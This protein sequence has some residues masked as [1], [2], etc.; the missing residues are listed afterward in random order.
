[1]TSEITAEVDISNTETGAFQLSVDLYGK[2]EGTYEET[3]LQ[4]LNKAHEVCPYSNATRGN[5]LVK[6]HLED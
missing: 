1:M 4:L 5:I 3:A 6:L 2:I